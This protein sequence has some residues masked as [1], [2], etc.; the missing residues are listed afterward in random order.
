MMFK[1]QKDSSASRP[2][3]RGPV[4]K[5]PKIESRDD[6]SDDHS[7]ADDED[8]HGSLFCPSRYLFD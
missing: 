1:T 8:E 5:K 2:V 7:N 3:V 6:P 4:S